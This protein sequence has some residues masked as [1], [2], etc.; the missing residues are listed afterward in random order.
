MRY[1]W[2]FL[3]PKQQLAQLLGGQGVWEIAV[4]VVLGGLQRGGSLLLGTVL[5]ARERSLVLVCSQCVLDHR[6]QSIPLLG[7]QFQGS[8]FCLLHSNPKECHM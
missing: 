2:G 3:L 5:L 8:W 7:R 4:T 1:Q 6:Y